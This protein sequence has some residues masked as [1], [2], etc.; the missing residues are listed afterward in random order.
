MNL[1]TCFWEAI[2]GVSQIAEGIHSMEKIEKSRVRGEP[3]GKSE[4][5]V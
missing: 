4:I 3:G 2:R 5:T 1:K